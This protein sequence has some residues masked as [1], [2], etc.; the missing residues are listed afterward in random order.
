VML[1]RP[2]EHLECDRVVE[3]QNASRALRPKF[4]VRV[5]TLSS[6][7]LAGGPI[8]EPSWDKILECSTNLTF[9]GA[10]WPGSDAW[11]PPVAVGTFRRDRRSRASLQTIGRLRDGGK[12][13]S[14]SGL[15]RDVSPLWFGRSVAQCKEI[16]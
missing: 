9:R 13:L 16:R 14:L 4:P 12:R 7:P 11:S 6:C 8:A 3:A 10:W 2:K 5:P 1:F 15:H